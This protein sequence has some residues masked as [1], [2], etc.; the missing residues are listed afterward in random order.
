MWGISTY[1]FTIIVVCHMEYLY[2]LLLTVI[3]I[4]IC[5][6]YQHS[7]PIAFSAILFSAH[8]NLGPSLILWYYI[9]HKA[10]NPQRKLI[11]SKVNH[12]GE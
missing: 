4:V 5:I 3:I 1:H 9:Y 2:V 12:K 6:E 11:N 10:N 8:R 7:R